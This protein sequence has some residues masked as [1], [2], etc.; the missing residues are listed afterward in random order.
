MEM[1]ESIP[2]KMT[3]WWWFVLSKLVLMIAK[4]STGVFNV[5]VLFSPDLEEVGT[6]LPLPLYNVLSTVFAEGLITLCTIMS[7]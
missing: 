4:A 6:L 7:W 5:Q 3:F 1:N 2:L